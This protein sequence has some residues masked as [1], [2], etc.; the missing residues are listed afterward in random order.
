MISFKEI[1]ERP[2]IKY[3]LTVLLVCIVIFFSFGI[4]EKKPA[5]N[6]EA[7][8]QTETEDTSQENENDGFYGIRIGTSNII[9]FA[10]LGGM[11]AGINIK[12]I[13]D[14]RQKETK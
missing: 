1:S 12:R 11:L 6:S 3:L 5:D 7:A 9:A 8:E 13:I 10:V 4:K 2:F 14:E